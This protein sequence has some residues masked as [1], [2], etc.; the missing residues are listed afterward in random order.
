MEWRGRHLIDSGCEGKV[1]ALKLRIFPRSI[2]SLELNV[3][4][5]SV[6]SMLLWR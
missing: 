5:V 3:L 6:G 2:K 1:A 4:P